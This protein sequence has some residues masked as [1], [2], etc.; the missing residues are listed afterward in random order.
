[1]KRAN[2]EVITTKDRKGNYTHEINYVKSQKDIFT[3]KRMEMIYDENIKL[4]K[5]FPEVS[6]ITKKVQIEFPKKVAEKEYNWKFA[7]CII[8]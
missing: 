6:K 8:A 1:M 5:D 2:V 4:Y 3:D 7:M